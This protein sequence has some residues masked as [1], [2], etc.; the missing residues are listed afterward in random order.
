MTG[1]RWVL[2]CAISILLAVGNAGAQESVRVRGGVHSDHGRMVFDWPRPLSYTVEQRG[3]RL[4]VA[5]ERPGVFDLSRI[6][7]QLP[8]YVTLPRVG[9]DQKSIAFGL[10]KSTRIEHF[11]LGG[12]VVVDFMH[13][14]TTPRREVSGAVVTAVVPEP[15]GPK[16]QAKSPEVEV[17]TVSILEMDDI[18]S[19]PIPPLEV[20]GPL[21]S[22][23]PPGGKDA[24]ES[25]QPR[26]VDDESPESLVEPVGPI[27]RAAAS[28]P[29]A[30][31]PHKSKVASGRN[32]GE[33]LF[34]VEDDPV[35][36]AREARPGYVASVPSPLLLRFDWGQETG[37]AAFQR[38][39]EVILVFD[40]DLPPNFDARLAEEA[41]RLK[42]VTLTT[43]ADASVLRFQ[44]APLIEVRLARDR[45]AWLIELGTHGEPAPASIPTKL[46][47]RDG[48]RFLKVAALGALTIVPLED[49]ATGL[50]LAVV[51]LSGPG[52]AMAKT[53]RFQGLS[54]LAS[55]QGLILAPASDRVE[56][57]LAKQSVDVLVEG[58]SLSAM[59]ESPE[60]FAEQPSRSRLFD[61][62]AWRQG[63]PES[64]N[65]RRKTLQ[66]AVVSAPRER[67]THARLELARFFFAY[68]MAS[69]TLGLLELVDRE[70]A[71]FADDAVSLL[72]RA[73]SAVLVDDF[74]RAADL[75]DHPALV[76]E[77]EADL[78]RGMLAAAGQDW[79]V[80]ASKL[81]AFGDLMD[82]YARGVQVR[83]RLAAAEAAL[84]VGD[85]S[86]A[87]EDLDDVQPRLTTSLEKAHFGFLQASRL[88]EIGHRDSAL[89]AF[90]RVAADGFGAP[91]ARARMALVRFGLE[92][93]SLTHGK[94]IDA[95]EKL[96]FAWR[97]DGFEFALLW[98]LSELYQ[99]EGDSRQALRALR[100]AATHFPGSRRGE[101]I[102]ARMCEV[103][104]AAFDPGA[105]SPLPALVSLSLYDEFPELTPAGPEGDAL[106][107]HLADRLV[108]V[109]LL[110]RAG[111]LLEH[112][113]RFR[114]SGM[115]KAATG[116]R[117]AT[118]RMLDRLPA[119]AL[120]ALD[121][122][123][124]DTAF[125]EELRDRRIRLRARALVDLGRP[126]EGLALLDGD[127]SERTRA[128][129]ARIFWQL[130]DWPRVAS[131]M[132]SLL[133]SPPWSGETLT[134]ASSRLVLDT[135]IALTLAGDPGGELE[136]LRRAYGSA[137]A[138]GP[139]KEAF[140][141]VAGESATARSGSLAAQLA[142]SDT[143]LAFMDSYRAGL[144]ARGDP[145]PE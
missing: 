137:M 58:A 119:A 90:E 16:P 35:P 95:L 60:E 142:A 88:M 37:V 114:L 87:A 43:Q 28:V 2:A 68:G 120:E 13:A 25:E 67:L 85:L 102:G 127:D 145:T 132:A 31:A 40:R 70:D 56:I 49:P 78:W 15:L 113:V 61:L 106:I 129:R 71:D 115:E 26:V 8:A 21:L 107:A 144:E 4:I 41:P 19:A 133:P 123:A 34:S 54:V 86:L 17:P 7:S 101:E 105:K 51:P 93:G 122:S 92:N 82:N 32:R 118:I 94:A 128:L 110:K 64:F 18:P 81:Q 112:Q 109:D 38:A 84:M 12:R 111:D 135:A 36:Y 23:G 14:N 121:V 29:L 20:P 143:A 74:E 46:V 48:E 27:E 136:G 117:L 39:S 98:R 45:T 24:I 131:E 73:A 138:L 103:F 125:P 9:A 80:A 53:Q 116:T 11:Q 124:D 139:H 6:S 59:H 66:G 62:A 75:L 83:L 140:V 57:A 104:L 44:V 10:V 141:L 79:R 3:D 33:F 76:D 5:F 72:M 1:V 134:A 96:R 100:E 63:P 69:E 30:P 89:E 126:N 77:A 91:A 55:A 50:E 130:N 22:S 99:A 42:E 108:E 52:Q 65:E 97:G 47:T